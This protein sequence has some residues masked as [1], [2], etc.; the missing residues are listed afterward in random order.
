MKRWILAL[1]VLLGGLI[2]LAQADYVIIIANLGLVKPKE[3]AQGQQ[4]PGMAG[5]G[6]M[7]AQG[8]GMMG[9]PGMGMGG[10]GMMGGPGMR[11]GQG[12]MGGPGMR[13]GQGQQGGQPQRP[14]GG[15]RPGGAGG[16]PGD[17][18]QPGAGPG[19]M[20]PGGGQ[21]GGQ[22]MMGGPGMGMG[23]QGMMGGPGM[24]G[25]QG[26]MGGPGMGMMGQMMG[27]QAGMMPGAGFIRGLGVGE[28][29][30]SAPFYVITVVE[31]KDSLSKPQL[32]A[33]R[34]NRPVLIEHK[35]GKSVLQSEAGLDIIVM[36]S[37]DKPFPSIR[38]RFLARNTEAHKDGNVSVDLLLD[39]D[40]NPQAGPAKFALEHRLLNEFRDVMAEVEK[41]DPNH[42]KVK[43]F[44]KVEK[45]MAQP[46]TKPDASAQ[47]KQR[48][49]L[50]DS[51]SSDHYVLLYS[52]G[53]PESE[54]TQRLKSLEDSYRGFFYWWAFSCDKDGDLA[55]MPKGKKDA[56]VV[57]DTRL[58][59]VLTAKEDEFEKD[60]KLFD[61][62]VLVADGFTDRRDNLSVYSIERLD[63]QYKALKEFSGPT[64]Q[65][66]GFSELLRNVW[67]PKARGKTRREYNVA[68]TLA[69]MIRSLEA[70]S[71]FATVTHEAPYQLLS[72][73]GLT[74]R[75]VVTPEWIGFGMP[76]FFAVTK[77]APWGG[78][79]GPNWIYLQEYKERAKSRLA[80]RMDKPLD[81]LKS[82]VSDRYF[83]Q[84]N[85]GQNEGALL[86]ARTLAWSLTYFLAHRK[87]GNDQ[88][89]LIRYY[90]ELAKM[91]RDL[92]FDQES[93]L[94]LFARAFDCLD[95][96]G[97]KPDDAKLT[98][99]A[100]EW[101]RFMD[102]TP[103]E[104][105][106]IVKDLRNRQAELKAGGAGKPEEKRKPEDDKPVEGDSK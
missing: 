74:H 1:L 71:E 105:E 34:N 42:P 78:A 58:V 53:A 40:T 26:M 84:T 6:M 43:A 88:Q 69:L 89:G 48:L 52:P 16:R 55:Y 9:G 45:A 15:Q 39:Y 98:K 35:W 47:W 51:K 68:S 87:L 41:L 57:P 8:M 83:H 12:M 28:E 66:F 100:E 44:Q 32:T 11:G 79:G 62:V 81:A 85:K 61:N 33:L 97:E 46:I 90:R 64:F 14:G 18:E 30:E 50:R 72:A 20:Q 36:K 70:D 101:Q 37:G 95:A 86:K 77:A 7:G 104:G 29:Q 94:H 73:I 82:V 91:P 102:L 63:K 22:G 38:K 19:G 27:G 59:S 23:G 80:G 103:L 10:Q 76:S 3:D 99:L 56:L 67:S 96:R 49:G 93:L 92:D 54:V 21:R 31:T 60:H 5:M 13:G 24:R 106:E 25:G 17:Q 65:E 4:Q 2:G 75:N